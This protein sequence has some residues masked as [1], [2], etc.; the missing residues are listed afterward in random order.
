MDQKTRRRSRRRERSHQSE[1]NPLVGLVHGVFA[2]GLLIVALVF[3]NGN[4]AQHADAPT[5]APSVESTQ[6]GR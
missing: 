6:L 5:V 3:A 4:Q 1:H 2:I